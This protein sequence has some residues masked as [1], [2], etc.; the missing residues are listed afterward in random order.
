MSKKSSKKGTSAK[1]AKKQPKNI[2]AGTIW[3][4]LANI[5]KSRG[6][7]KINPALLKSFC[8]G[9]G[10]AE[11]KGT[12]TIPAK[13]AFLVANKSAYGLFWV[14]GKKYEITA[15]ERCL[16]LLESILHTC[17]YPKFANVSIEIAA[18]IGCYGRGKLLEYKATFEEV[19]ETLLAIEQ[20]QPKEN[21]IYLTE[22]LPSQSSVVIGAVLAS[23]MV[24]SPDIKGSL[25]KAMTLKQVQQAVEPDAMIELTEAKKD[26]PDEAFKFF[27]AQATGKEAKK[28]NPLSLSEKKLLAKY[29]KNILNTQRLFYRVG[30]A[31]KEISDKKLYRRKNHSFDGYV[32]IC[33]GIR[34]DY[35]RKTILAVGVSDEI[36]GVWDGESDFSKRIVQ[37]EAQARELLKLKT[38]SERK[39][40][41]REA[42]EKAKNENHTMSVA[43]IQL[44][45]LAKKEAS[46]NKPY[47][48]TKAASELKNKW[49][50]FEKYY[51]SIKNKTE[52]MEPFKNICKG[53][54]LAP[55]KRVLLEIAELT[56][57]ENNG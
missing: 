43:D 35:A 51:E 44:V 53:E 49:L 32:R 39:E 46:G 9:V 4:D 48:G 22:I 13:T 50:S 38:V 14:N 52:A 47:D 37:S 54:L 19:R 6:W 29:E 55:I 30:F 3:I 36:D 18:H 41:A 11:K 34:Y 33:L 27:P 25:V 12:M 24:K 23:G 2:N 20:L 16:P 10:I 57:K 26:F 5:L 56:G 45:I 1:K 28:E 31:L 15:K 21:K 7:D 42:Y 40:V 8:L 17:N